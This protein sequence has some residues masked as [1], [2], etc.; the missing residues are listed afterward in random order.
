M[1]A[2]KRIWQ[3]PSFLRHGLLK[4]ID[5]CKD[6]IWFSCNMLG[7]SQHK[8][9]GANISQTDVFGDILYFTSESPLL[10]SDYV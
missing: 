1:R 7:K 5:I 4:K 9:I 8:H 2:S 6:Q 10:H 3:T